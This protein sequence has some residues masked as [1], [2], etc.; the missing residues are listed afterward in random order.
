MA[1]TGLINGT[2]LAVYIG[3]AKIDLQTSAELKLTMTPRESRTKDST[4]YASRFDGIRDWEISSEIEIAADATYGIT[5]LMAAWLADTKLSIAFKTCVSG[6]MI[7]GGDAYIQ[8]IS[9]SAGVEENATASITF[10]GD[11]ELSKT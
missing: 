3:A 9:Q 8:E 4:A 11:G 2:L 7:L 10:T 1:T 6:D 5:Q